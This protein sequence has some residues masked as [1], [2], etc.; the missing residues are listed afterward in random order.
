[1]KLILEVDP[2]DP[3]EV[4]EAHAILTILGA[5]DFKSTIST[6]AAAASN[7]ADDEARS[8]MQADRDAKAAQ[9]D[10]EMEATRAA[11]AEAKKAAADRA[12][13]KKAEE[14]AAKKEAEEKAA[15][16]SKE[17]PSDIS[18][19]ALQEMAAQLLAAGQRRTLKSILD[20][21]GAPSLSG[22]EEGLYPA[23]HKELTEAVEGLSLT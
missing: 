18:L 9:A 8:K 1:M 22:A 11:A 4:G 20:Q 7:K 15:A 13:A 2:L 12:A 3:K 10:A 14:E 6:Q 19:P 23:L 21:V 5:G 16:E 17:A